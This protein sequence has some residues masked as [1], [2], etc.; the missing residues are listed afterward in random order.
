MSLSF[1]TLWLAGDVFNVIGAI[2]QHVLPTMIVLA[3]YYTLADIVLI[4]QWFFYNHQEEETIDP[5]HLSPATPL[6]QEAYHHHHHEDH[7]HLGTDYGA[8]QGQ[9]E[10]AISS[11]EEDSDSTE[12]EAFEPVPLW[13]IVVLNIILVFLVVLAGIV[14]WAFSISGKQLEEPHIPEKDVPLQFNL[15]GQI[16][17][18]LCAVLYL[19]SRIPQLLLN[20]KRKSCE[21]ISFLF[22]LFACLGNLTFVISILANSLSKEYLLI[23]AS[24]LVGSIGTLLLDELIFIQFWIYSLDEDSDSDTSI[25]CQE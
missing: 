24:W 14:G 19:G 21:G 9:V 18:W 6:L 15:P 17:G 13:K 1:L 3:I 25:D 22:F 11:E 4:I 8:V 23:N 2:L 7:H 16:F 12:S 10:S 20:F 5:S